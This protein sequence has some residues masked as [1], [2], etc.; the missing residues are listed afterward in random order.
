MT[1]ILYLLFINVLAMFLYW[2]DKR[3]A[4][5]N[6]M[7]V[8]EYVLL[9]VGFLGGTVGA[10]FART[11]FRHKTKKLSFRLQF[12]ALTALQI[13]LLLHPPMALRV[14]IGKLFG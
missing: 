11:L 13:Y 4:R 9:L 2:H 14:L 6:A 5:R 1:L 8:P 12:W 10:L 3:A 7:R